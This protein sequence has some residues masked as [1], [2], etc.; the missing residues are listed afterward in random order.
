[1]DKN[2]Q[3]S[4]IVDKANEIVK[5]YYSFKDEKEDV[6]KLIKE[7]NHF[8]DKI[9]TWKVEQGLLNFLQDI[10]VFI[11][12]PQ[13]FEM[14]IRLSR[15]ECC[16]DIS[17]ETLMTEICSSNLVIEKIKDGEYRQLHLYQKEVIDEFDCE[18]VNRY[19]L[20][21]PTS[22]G[23]T[24]VVPRIM[25][26]M[27]Y[28]NVVLIFP[29]LSL[30]A[31]NYLEISNNKVF[32]DFGVH[33]L[34]EFDTNY[35]KN[36]W[37][38]TPERFLSMTDK[39]PK[40]K[41][42]FIFMDEVYKIDNQYILQDSIGENERDVAYRI[43]LNVA[44]KRGKDILLAGPFIEL[45]NREK[46]YSINNFFDENGFTSLSYNNIEIVGKDVLSLIENDDYSF[47]DGMQFKITNADTYK[48][49]N[50]VLIEVKNN[51]ENTIIYCSGRA[52]AEKIGLKI[53][54]MKIFDIN[55]HFKNEQAKTEYEEFIE[56]L[57]NNFSEHWTIVNGLMN[58]VGIHHG[59]VP[60]Y[61]QKEIIRY[62]NDGII[63]CLVSTT[64][65]TEGINT[66]AKN[67]IVLSHM[68]GKKPLKKFDA[69]NIAGRAGRFFHHFS[70]RV[71]SINNNFESILN[72]EAEILNHKNYDLKAPK[73]EVDYEITPS[74]YLS[75]IDKL[76]KEEID[77]KVAELGIP[78]ELFYQYK[79]VKPAK[80]LLAYETIASFSEGEFA[81]IDILIKSLYIY[82]NIDWSCFDYFINKL[83]ILFDD[84]DWSLN[85]LAER[86]PGKNFS[87]LTVK[88]FNYFERGY[89]GLLEYS[90]STNK[91]PIDKNIRDTSELVFNIFR[92]QLCRYVG[93]FD[94]FYR[95]I[96][97]KKLNKDINEIVGFSTL[98]QKLE[99][100]S[101]TELGK[102]VSD[103]G[104]PFSVAEYID[105]NE[106][107]V[108][109]S[110]DNYEKKIYD[111]VIK[112]FN[113]K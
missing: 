43:A 85:F 52:D 53:I 100:G 79:S 93:V 70:G 62:F 16:F 4:Y 63:K 84:S 14:F 73:N 24:F 71:I 2:K 80:K 39:N 105:K 113:M 34:S 82:G 98:L 54:Q 3:T 68:K 55:A 102:K 64:T 58:G 31:Q 5:I 41:F 76:K 50:K 28:N 49:L 25:Q 61:I 6:S 86:K 88:V 32:E 66:T 18:A 81:I 22:F 83:K 1:M 33:T 65:I 8:F 96:L 11:G 78:R 103:F 42:D 27:K 104:V 13:Y 20:T 38:Y 12:L 67:M 69:Q 15:N 26:K 89:K 75:E 46:N 47:D 95:Y 21:A 94:I 9:K 29:T 7:V 40:I 99:Y 10:S 37:I 74:K 36:I 44:C 56:H 57:K 23:K 48:R 17:S 91:L 45:P 106:K 97:S 35:E 60:K 101:I 77:K 109:D 90:I 72:S 92:F 87:T 111:E 51:N 30:L 108:K 110:F 112:K 107:S 19:I 59:Y